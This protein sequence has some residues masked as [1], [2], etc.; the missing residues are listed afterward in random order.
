MMDVRTRNVVLRTLAKSYGA[1]RGK[2]GH[3]SCDD[4]NVV[5]NGTSNKSPMRQM[6]VDIELADGDGEWVRELVHELPR[7]YLGDMVLAAKVSE[8][9]DPDRDIEEYLE[10]ETIS[11]AKGKGDA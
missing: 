8:P 11:K 3:P 7:E 9:L 5:Y 10:D 2:F 4:V 1:I 6:I